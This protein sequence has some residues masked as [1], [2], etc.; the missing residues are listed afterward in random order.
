MRK[1]LQVLSLRTSQSLAYMSAC[2][3]D[4]VQGDG[5]HHGGGRQEGGHQAR[6]DQVGRAAAVLTTQVRLR[7]LANWEKNI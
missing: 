4:V 7:Y 2:H 5:R 1:L 3:V 6:R